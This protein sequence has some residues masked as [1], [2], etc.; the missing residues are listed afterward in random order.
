[1]TGLIVMLGWGTILLWIAAW[2]IS[3]RLERIAK[4]LE[5]LA[6]TET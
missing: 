1:M 4:A 5:A 2:K 6:D 3:N